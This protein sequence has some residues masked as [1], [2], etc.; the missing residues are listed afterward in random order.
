MLMDISLV[1]SVEPR[2]RLMN[3]RMSSPSRELQVIKSISKE[4][5]T[6]KSFSNSSQY[7]AMFA[8]LCF[9]EIMEMLV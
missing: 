2:G 7:D 8:E 5:F 3:Y 6:K 9:Y 1:P 4:T